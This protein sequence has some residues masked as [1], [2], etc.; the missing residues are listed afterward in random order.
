[1]GATKM[2]YIK[3]SH[4]YTKLEED[5][6]PTIRRYDR[7]ELSQHITVKTPTKTFP[8]IIIAKTK[9]RL[10]Q[11]SDSFLFRDTDTTNRAEAIKVLNSFYRKPIVE[12]EVLTIL[13]IEK[14]RK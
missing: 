14:V 7:Y 10:E 11:L 2:T 1:M 13:I 9:A 8:A 6:F 3:F 5:T 12:D 4:D